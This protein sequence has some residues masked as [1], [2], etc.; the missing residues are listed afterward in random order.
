MKTIYAIRSGPYIKIGITSGT[1]ESRMS[2]LQTGNP[3]KLV[4][5]FARTID[6]SNDC[7]QYSVREM[8]KEIHQRLDEWR[9]EGEW[10]M[11]PPAAAEEE[12]NE[13]VDDMISARRE[14]GYGQ[15]RKSRV[16]TISLGNKGF[17]HLLSQCNTS[18][19]VEM[20][21]SEKLKREMGK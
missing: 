12:I 4:I 6:I 11:I 5:S 19:F 3:H 7:Y 15:V 20:A 21:V 18:L 10:F 16:V 2:S 8:E 9:A 14:P 17:E 13:V 1:V